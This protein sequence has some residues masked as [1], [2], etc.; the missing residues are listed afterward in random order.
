MRR[1]SQHLRK[2][3][4]CGHIPGYEITSKPQASCRIFTLYRAK[5]QAG[6][7]PMKNVQKLADLHMAL[8]INRFLYQQGKITQ[9]MFASANQI[10]TERLLSLEKDLASALNKTA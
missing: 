10:F 4:N 1:S 9:E 7:M 2:P 3:E 5:T 8:Q 6:G